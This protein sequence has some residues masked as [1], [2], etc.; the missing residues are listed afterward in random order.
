MS[1]WIAFL[2]GLTS[3]GLT[4]MAAQGG[5]LAGILA[6]QPGATK[7]DWRWSSATVPTA[8]F[9]GAKFV[10]HLLLGALLG[11]IGA[12][13]QLS[14]T[15]RLG[16]QV[17]AAVFI[18]TAGIRLRWP[19][20]LPWLN[21]ELPA[22]A[23]R[24][25]RRSTKLDTVAAPAALG[26]LTVLIPCGT[27]QA[28]MFAAIAT[29]SAAAGAAIMGAFVLG[30]AP[31]FFLIGV[32]AKGATL[33][34][35]LGVIAAALVIGVGLYSLN[36]V[37]VQ[38]DSPWSFQN[39]V[40]AWRWGLSGSSASPNFGVA[41]TSPTITVLADGYEPREITVPAGKPVRLTLST[42]ENIGC[43]SVFRIPKVKI[44]R[45]LP[46]TG[47]TIVT[48]TF[49]EPGEYTFSCGMGMYSGKIRAI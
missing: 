47:Q 32:L 30:T 8:G 34:P 12:G 18:I 23:R 26:F 25:V 46:E 28:M 5:L 35:R 31:L 2:T 20:F 29:G 7:H 43:T 3:G 10:A 16:F 17:L 15:W 14:D 45:V 41:T 48:A 4:C 42:K 44:E 11:W 37:L 21:F 39:Q 22:G 6:R 27:T 9:I 40:A 19:N 49:P 33:R 13:V 36:G 24:L 38:L 1:P